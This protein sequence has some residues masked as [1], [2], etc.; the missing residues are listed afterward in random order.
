MTGTQ[1]RSAQRL[2]HGRRHPV[3]APR[4]GRPAADPLVTAILG[5]QAERP[6]GSMYTTSRYRR[7]QRRSE[8]AAVIRRR[9]WAL[10]ILIAAWTLGIAVTLWLVATWVG[11]PAALFTHT[12]MAVLLVAL[13]HCARVE[14][15]WLDRVR[16][17]RR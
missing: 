9:L 11:W 6:S 15:R 13:L 1:P 8:D 7:A 10:R 4:P 5:V 16:A 14:R 17:E 12:P 3:P 2:I